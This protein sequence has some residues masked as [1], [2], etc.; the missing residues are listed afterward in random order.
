MQ[1]IQQRPQLFKILK[2]LK[3]IVRNRLTFRHTHSIYYD[4]PDVLAQIAS[5][6]QQRKP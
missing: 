3:L 1:T 5:Q 4:A 6:S 2:T